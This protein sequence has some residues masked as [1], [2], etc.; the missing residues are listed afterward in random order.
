M[1][2]ESTY[3][4]NF[5]VVDDEPT[6]EPKPK[7]ENN[8]TS[9]DKADFA[10]SSSEENLINKKRHKLRIFDPEGIYTFRHIEIGYFQSFLHAISALISL[11]LIIGFYYLVIAD[12]KQVV[13]GI[14]DV[15][16]INVLD[17]LAMSFIAI[18]GLLKIKKTLTIK[19]TKFDIR[20]R[21]ALC[22]NSL[23]RIIFNYLKLTFI[24]STII[25]TIMQVDYPDK[26]VSAALRIFE[27]GVLADTLSII[28]WLISI[29]IVVKAFKYC[30]KG[31]NK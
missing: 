11:F 4:P 1:H 20:Y 5:T 28:T 19:V 24:C 2:G 30:G 13:T 16:D 27:N 15:S 14:G 18:Y 3:K 23:N 22:A 29:I 25:L 31:E 26:T 8:K 7:K 10:F 17:K 21:V 6:S 9:N 12:T